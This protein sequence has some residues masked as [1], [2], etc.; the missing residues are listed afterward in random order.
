M[1]IHEDPRGSARI[2][3]DPRRSLG[4]PGSACSR[5]GRMLWFPSGTSEKLSFEFQLE[6]WHNNISQRDWVIVKV[7]DRSIVAVLT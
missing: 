3:D 7:S 6:T 2:H 1:K 4:S 5:L